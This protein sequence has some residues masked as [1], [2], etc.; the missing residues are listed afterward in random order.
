MESGLGSKQDRVDQECVGE[1]RPWDVKRVPW[2]S[3]LV[4]G[5][6]LPVSKMLLGGLDSW[7]QRGNFEDVG[8][9]ARYEQPPDPHT[10]VS[11]ARWNQ[12]HV[13]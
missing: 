6:E 3:W 12:T 1:E 13:P 8:K 7:S 9:R 11:P 5:L 10:V 2:G 4:T